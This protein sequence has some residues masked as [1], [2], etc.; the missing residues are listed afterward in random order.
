MSSFF[1]HQTFFYQNQ[2]AA[3][4]SLYLFFNHFSKLYE[5]CMTSIFPYTCCME[6]YDKRFSCMEV[7]PGSPKFQSEVHDSSQKQ[8]NGKFF[9]ILRK[10]FEICSGI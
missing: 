7:N 1:F 8:K 3:E 4:I 2:A 6:F 5:Y 10:G 9:S